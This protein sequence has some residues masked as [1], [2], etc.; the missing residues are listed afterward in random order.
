MIVQEYL[1]GSQL[2]YSS[3]LI[4]D[5][6]HPQFLDGKMIEFWQI[7]YLIYRSLSRYFTGLFL[8]DWFERL[9]PPPLL[10]EYIQN[11]TEST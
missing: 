9:T 10:I 7:L 2:S 1:L 5:Q 11:A 3:K 8:R 4:C 6:A